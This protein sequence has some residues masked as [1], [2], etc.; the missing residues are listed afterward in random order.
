MWYVGRFCYMC[1]LR[2][3]LSWRPQRR[4][5][6]TWQVSVTVTQRLVQ[7][8][9]KCYV[10]YILGGMKSIP[11]QYCLQSGL[12]VLLSEYHYKSRLFFYGQNSPRK[13]PCIPALICFNSFLETG[14]SVTVELVQVV[15]IANLWAKSVGHCLRECKQCDWPAVSKLNHMRKRIVET[16]LFVFEK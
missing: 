1:Q 13:S 14:F 12:Q 8:V 3:R 9:W 10:P 5:R 16:S 2:Q 11:V 4:I 7:F 6:E 15:S